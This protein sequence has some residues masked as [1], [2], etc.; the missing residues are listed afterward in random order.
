M[1]VIKVGGNE[2]DNA[3]F[4]AGLADALG[5]LP[6]P[7]VI[8]H[9]GGRGT[10]MLMERFGLEPRF[11]EGLRVT[12]AQ[13]LEL[14][15]M[16]M[17]GQAST[18]L[19]QALCRAGLPALGLSGVDAALVTAERLRVAGGDLG[20]VGQPV[21]VDAA[22]L[23][24]LRGAG[25]VPCLAPICR[26][27][28]GALLNVNADAVAQSV[29]AALDAELLLFLTNVPAVK[30]EGAPVPL[31][32]PAAI[33]REIARGEIVGGMIPKTRG[34]VAALDAGVRRV[35]ITDLAGLTALA[36]GDRAGTTIT[37]DA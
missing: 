10:S 3:G 28:S 1:I 16:G 7:P 13:T 15:V 9:G 21:A 6:E 25:F 22:R 37:R 17:V 11:V 8:V 33:E 36:R 35:L 31:L 5:A 19:V 24:A 32:T 29:A 23:H 18:Q 34:A 26:D 20:A 30:I 2:L 27:A 4:L 14:A 12:D